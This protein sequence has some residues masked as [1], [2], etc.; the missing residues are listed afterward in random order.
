LIWGSG[1]A[2][3]R[4]ITLKEEASELTR[5]MCEENMSK[6]IFVSGDVIQ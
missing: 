4:K 1:P 2:V 6:E 3:S 5:V